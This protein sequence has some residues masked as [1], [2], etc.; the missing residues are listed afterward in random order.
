MVQIGKTC[1]LEVVKQVNF[2]VYLNA[3]ELGQVLLPNKVTPKDCQVGDLLDVFLYLDSEDIVIAT[4]RRPL[5]Q[6][7]EF[8][9]LKAVATGPY[10]AF[11]DWGL[12]KDLLLPFGEQHKPIE[13]GRSYLVYVHANRADERIMASSK[14]DKFLDKTEPDYTVGQQ[15]DL[16]IG[17]TTD[18]GY[19]AIIN[20]AHWGVIFENEV[21]QK[22]RFGQRVKGFIKQVRNDG[23]IDLVLQQGSKEELDKHAHI[24]LIKLKQA[25]GFL[26]LTDKTDA[27]IIYDQ[28]GM[29]KKAFKK[30]IG[31][32]FKSSRLS[33]DNDGLRLT[34]TAE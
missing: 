18:L 8:A 28:L 17:G 3:H 20:H 24:I 13:E 30:A 2:G 32:L 11:L 22:L 4:T 6:V 7:G 9:Y 15:V 5:A 12:D 33:I 10:G 23:K 31:G 19:K 34:E 29:S 26:P 16:Y 21:F 25:G 14:I 27:E 1:K